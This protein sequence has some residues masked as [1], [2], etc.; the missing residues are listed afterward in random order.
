MRVS[1]YTNDPKIKERIEY[2]FNCF[3][4]VFPKTQYQDRG[5]I[6]GV[7][8]K[9]RHLF[10]YFRTEVDGEK[11]VKFKGFQNSVNILSDKQIIDERIKYTLDLFSN[12]GFWLMNKNTEIVE[13]HIEQSTNVPVPDFI[14]IKYRKVIDAVPE[15]YDNYA[16]EFVCPS[17]IATILNENNINTI[18]DLRKQ[19]VKDLMAMP[20]FG[21]ASYKQ[22][23]ITLKNIVK[24]SQPI[25]DNFKFLHYRATR[26]SIRTFENKKGVQ[27]YLE[28]IEYDESKFE[29]RTLGRVLCLRHK[30]PSNDIFSL[31]NDGEYIKRLYY[32]NYE[33]FDE[34]FHKFKLFAYD[35]LSVVLEQDRNLP[36]ISTMLGLFDAPR[37]LQEVGDN[38]NITR[39]R[40][41]QIFKKG[42]AKK[43]KLFS[44]KYEESIKRATKQFE[45]LSELSSIGIE[46]FMLY[47]KI[48][49]KKQIYVVAKALL[50]EG[51]TI[52]DNFFEVINSISKEVYVSNHT[53]S[54]ASYNRSYNG[55]GYKGCL[56]IV[57]EN[58]EVLTDIVLLE[59]LREK[60]KELATKYKVDA[61]II[62]SNKQ[63]VS[64]ATYKPTTKNSYIEIYGLG[65]KSWD[66]YGCIMVDI[67]KEYLKK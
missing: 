45:L 42:L 37:T 31:S 67:I 9:G 18:N 47:L 16:I 23:L 7:G 36:M 58:N 57:D 39:E 43:Y 66:K 46:P 27:S 33:L 54:N 32:K 59:K 34:Y 25:E 49:H 60:R 26:S 64:L 53:V 14:E 56:L 8:E 63:L 6:I 2:I 30:M 28:S 4:S 29:S 5:A 24:V 62:F 55:V 10:C 50:L 15:E 21:Q 11:T 35:M 41:N 44:N 12:Q 19:T 17:R 13:K 22:L 38:Y 40:V 65:L 3:C 51:L 20:G 61:Y 52:P 1:S 48:K